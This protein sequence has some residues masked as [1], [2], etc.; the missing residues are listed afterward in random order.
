MERKRENERKEKRNKI[1]YIVW[2][3]N[4]IRNKM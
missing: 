2:H 1:L 3:A 4:K